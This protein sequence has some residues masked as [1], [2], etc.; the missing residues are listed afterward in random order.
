MKIDHDI[1]IP[2]RNPQG[3]APKYPWRQMRVGDSFL[4]PHEG[5]PFRYYQTL[6]NATGRS[7]GAHFCVG[8]EA[9]TARIWRTA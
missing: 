7:M 9:G 4:V 5:K 2:K 1:P 6:A 3:G 8:R